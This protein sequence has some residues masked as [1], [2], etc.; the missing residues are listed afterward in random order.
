VCFT[1]VVLQCKTINV[2]AVGF[3]IQLHLNLHLTQVR[4]FF[5]ESKI[6]G[7]SGKESG[8]CIFYAYIHDK[9]GKLLFPYTDHLR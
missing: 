8:F 5:A 2:K 7:K 4:D 1:I 9:C 3:P 6:M